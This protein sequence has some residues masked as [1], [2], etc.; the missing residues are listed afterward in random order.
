[1]PDLGTHSP[2]PAPS[3][4][5]AVEE[6]ALRLCHQGAAPGGKKGAIVRRLR[7]MP[8]DAALLFEDETLLRWFPPLRHVWAF[9]GEQAVVPITGRNAKRVLFGALNP[10]TGHRLI[11]RRSRQTQED[12]QVFLG[13][14]RRH[15]RGRPIWLLLDR[16]PAHD[17]AH[18]RRLAERL[19]IELIWLPKQ[20]SELNAVDQ[21]WK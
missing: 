19:G 17:A 18:S 20:C 13:Y 1:L 5:L 11:L 10:K 8:A 16:A 4:G 21:L 2:P 3:A 14:L 7:A 12:F 6:A 15:Y 9:R